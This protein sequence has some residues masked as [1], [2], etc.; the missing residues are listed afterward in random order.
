MS[1]WPAAN[2]GESKERDALVQQIWHERYR[3]NNWITSGELR[4]DSCHSSLSLEAIEEAVLARK[5]TINRSR[6]EWHESARIGRRPIAVWWRPPARASEAEMG[7]RRAVKAVCCVEGP[8]ASRDPLGPE[9]RGA[10]GQALQRTGEASTPFLFS[11]AAAAHVSML[12][13]PARS[14]RSDQ[15][16]SRLRA[17]PIDLHGGHLHSIRADVFSYNELS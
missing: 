12:D 8:P 7:L 3:A 6:L 15:V 17:P 1:Y 10:P 13:A 5:A 9:E 2:N 11:A 14:R 16:F 4:P